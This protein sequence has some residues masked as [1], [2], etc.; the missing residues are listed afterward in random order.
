MKQIIFV[1]GKNPKPET[2]L[3]RELLWRSLVE[4]VRRADNNLAAS[5]NNHYDQFQLIGWN[6][7]YYHANKDST[8]DLPWIDALIN[9]H[10][11][12]KQDIREANSWNIKLSRL[13]LT[14]A[15]HVPLLIQLLPQEV[16]STANEIDRYFNNVGNVADKMRGMLK[17]KLRPMLERKEAV[18]LIGHSLGSVIA[19]DAL[20]ELSHQEHIKGKVDFLTLGSPLG[21]HYIKKRLLGMKDPN[22]AS[23]PALIHHWINIAAEGDVTALERNFKKSFRS[24]L[25]QGLVD[26]I[27]DHCDGIYNYYSNSMG[28]NPHRSYGYLVNPV[29]GNII[30]NWWKQP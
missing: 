13:L 15:D 19:Y 1:P 30:A 26:S 9:K 25:Q 20:W 16:R 14:A 7:L 10:G 2:S 6:Y 8:V 12:S 5:L 11:P 4:G 27:E 28:L 3:H 29:V 23:Y 22:Q 18:F 21:M 24:M 17:V